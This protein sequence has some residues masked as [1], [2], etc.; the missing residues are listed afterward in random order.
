MGRPAS[1]SFRNKTTWQKRQKQGNR[2][3][4]QI[5]CHFPCTWAEMAWQQSPLDERGKV[6]VTHRI[7]ELKKISITVFTNAKMR[8]LHGLSK[9]MQ[10]GS[11][12]SNH[13]QEAAMPEPPKARWFFFGDFGDNIAETSMNKEEM[14]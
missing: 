7:L 12:E 5:Y 3:E 10:L 13:S 8:H 2:R 9:S 6:F 4:D 11:L 14:V 1:P